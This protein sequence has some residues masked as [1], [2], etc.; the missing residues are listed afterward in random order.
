MDSVGT[1]GV[2]IGGPVVQG[3]GADTEGPDV[4]AAG[5]AETGGPD[6]AIC[7]VDCCHLARHGDV[8]RSGEAALG[9]STT[10]VE[11]AAVRT[12]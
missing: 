3:G 9:L 7:C 1:S 10:P 6:N 5:G 4:A 11:A 12:A 8:L 2:D